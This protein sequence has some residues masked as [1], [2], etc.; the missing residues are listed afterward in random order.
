MAY[1]EYDSDVSESPAEGSVESSVEKA[2]SRQE[3]RAQGLSRKESRDSETPKKPLSLGDKVL[4]G[5]KSNTIRIED[6]EESLSKVRRKNGDLYPYRDGLGRTG[7]KQAAYER[8]ERTAAKNG[9]TVPNALHDYHAMETAWRQDPLLGVEAT[10]RRLG[11]DPRALAYRYAVEHGIV[12][13]QNIPRQDV[14]TQA[15]MHLQQ[16]KNDADFDRYSNIRNMP[17]TS[18]TATP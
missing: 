1:D 10:A 13:D 15:L 7:K 4:A 18:P 9:T 2:M 14:E 3:G 6:V 12:A 16:A 5:A 17:P 11:Y 8:F